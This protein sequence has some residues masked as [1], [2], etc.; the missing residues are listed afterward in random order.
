MTIEQI[1]SEH[2][3]GK[4]TTIDLGRMSKEQG[5]RLAKKLNGQTFMDFQI[6]VAPDGGEWGIT[7]QTSYNAS[8]DEI[9]GMFLYVMASELAG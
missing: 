3:D 2:M 1:T 6:Q 4:L 9:L 7:A 5:D 8:A